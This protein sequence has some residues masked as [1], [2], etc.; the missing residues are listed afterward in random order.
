MF[1]LRSEQP[2]ALKSVREWRYDPAELNGEKVA[3][4]LCV[5]VDFKL[6]RVGELAVRAE[7]EARRLCSTL[8]FDSLKVNSMDGV[9]EAT[10]ESNDRI[11]KGDAL[12]VDDFEIDGDGLSVEIALSS[13]HTR[14]ESIPVEIA[15]YQPILGP[16]REFINKNELWKAFDAFSES[17]PKASAPRDVKPKKPSNTDA[18][19]VP[20]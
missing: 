7:I 2:S 16:K 11:R 20:D 13:E 12:V 18:T 17:C 3:V 8:D 4:W 10:N 6:L 1:G 9:T 15:L 19:S 5:L 14:E